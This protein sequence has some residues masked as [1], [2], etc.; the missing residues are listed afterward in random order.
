MN[1]TPDKPKDKINTGRAQLKLDERYFPRGTLMFIEGETSTEMFIVRSGK[2]RVLKLEGDKTIE[3]AVLGL[4]SVLGELALLD[5]QP[6]SATAQVIEDVHATV[7]DEK[8]FQHTM[9][10]VPSWLANMIQVVVSR[11]RETMKKTSDSVV[12][13]SVAG[14]IKVLLLLYNHESIEAEGQKRLFLSRAKDAI[15]S[16]IGIG[17]IE[18]ESVFLHLILKEL[19]LIQKDDAGREYIILLDPHALGLYM[20]YLRTCVHGTKLLGQ[21]L[22]DKGMELLQFLLDTG[23]KNG[24]QIKPGIIRLGV[25]QIEIE[26]QRQGKGKFI[27]LDALE[28]LLNQKVIFKEQESV[29][30]SPQT[31]KQLSLLYNEET[32]KKVILLHLWLPKYKED[33]KI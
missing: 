3:L 15:S 1:R 26:I 7:I 14:V 31:Y 27:D 33:V 8:M 5:H 12:Q 4:G 30:V 2:I 28:E 25:S 20:N 21:E 32:L 10:S 13:K 18:S 16:V 22:S 11:L 29:K 19:M 17:D 24:R 23:A 9:E 6:R